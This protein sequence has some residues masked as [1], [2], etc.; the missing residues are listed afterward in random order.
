[1]RAKVGEDD[2][3][4]YQIYAHHLVFGSGALVYIGK[5][6]EQTFGVRI[7]QH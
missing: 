5:A 6:Q 7:A 4:L 1:V 3:G 2:Y